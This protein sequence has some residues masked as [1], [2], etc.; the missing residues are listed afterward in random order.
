MLLEL[1]LKTEIS[2]NIQRVIS[3][4]D[5]TFLIVGH[6]GREVLEFNTSFCKVTRQIWKE[7]GGGLVVCAE[8]ESK[9]RTLFFSNKRILSVEVSGWAEYVEK[10]TREEKLEDCVVLFSSICRDIRTPLHGLVVG[11][12]QSVC[13]YELKKT[14][15]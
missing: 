10:L 9:R 1:A 4:F 6:E 11:P 12:P 5:D 2:T 14:Q 13:V 3:L 8:D 7:V 15:R